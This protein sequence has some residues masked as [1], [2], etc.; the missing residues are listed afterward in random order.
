[1]GSRFSPLIGG[2]VSGGSLAGTDGGLGHLKVANCEAGVDSALIRPDLGSSSSG[3]IGVETSQIKGYS[4]PKS[5][6]KRPVESN[7][8][9]QNNKDRMNNF[10]NS[11]SFAPAAGVENL[12]EGAAQACGPSNVLPDGPSEERVEL[13]GPLMTNG[14]I[15]NGLYNITSNGPNIILNNQYVGGFSNILSE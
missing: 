10:S 7:D 5:A 9:F 14:L 8:L 4:G 6:G 11:V 12:K 1:M 2:E 13:K 15:L 3:P